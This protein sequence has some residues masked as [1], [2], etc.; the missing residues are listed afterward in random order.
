M[1]RQ[2]TKVKESLTDLQTTDGITFTE[3]EDKA[4]CLNN[5]FTSVFTR[6]DLSDVPKLEDRPFRNT[7]EDV[8]ID[9]ERVFKLLSRIKID[10]SPGPDGIHNRVLSETKDQVTEPLTMIFKASMES[11]L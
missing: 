5:F 4:N 6:E 7:L 2:K 11:G 1:V 8:P 10:K 3:N 9:E